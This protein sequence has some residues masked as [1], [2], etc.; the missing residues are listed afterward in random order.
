MPSVETNG[1]YI[2]R[3]KNKFGTK[4]L[5]TA[6]LELRN[7]RAHLIGTEG[8][9]IHEISTILN[10]SRLWSSVSAV[11][12]LGRG[13][14]IVKAWAKVRRVA[15]G[16]LLKDN[17]LHM[18][19]LA[20]IVSDYHTSMLFVFLVAYLTGIEEHADALEV[21]ET[22]QP[23]IRPKSLSHTQALLRVMTSILKAVVCKKSIHGLQECMEALG[24]V[25][26][27]DNSEN[28]SINIARLYRDC[29]VLSIWEGTTDGL[30][31]LCKINR[32]LAIKWWKHEG[33]C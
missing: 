10:I 5:P 30:L 20:T 26:Y 21:A 11:G 18:S 22:Y 29:C 25:G 4:S 16:Q 19:T 12:Y 14:A 28:E 3:L 24:G 1:I 2:Q 13:I 23:R 27:L 32:L 31:L 6:E 9:G 33:Q 15:K 7:T 8:R 17:D